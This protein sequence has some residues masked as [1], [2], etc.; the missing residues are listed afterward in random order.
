M[1]IL[2]STAATNQR[3][4]HVLSDLVKAFIDTESEIQTNLQS[5]GFID[6]GHE[7]GDGQ[8]A[9]GHNSTLKVPKEDDVLSSLEEPITANGNNSSSSPCQT[10]GRQ[11]E[12]NGSFGNHVTKRSKR[13]MN[14]DDVHV[15]FADDGPDL[16]TPAFNFSIGSD[17]SP[18]D[19]SNLSIDDDVV[20]GAS[21]RLRNAVD[22][23]LNLLK[24][25]ANLQIVN[26]GSNGQSSTESSVELVKNP[27]MITDGKTMSKNSAESEKIIEKL[28]K[29]LKDV[30]RANQVLQEE[31]NNKHRQLSSLKARIDSTNV[32]DAQSLKE[33]NDNLKLI[34]E[35][36]TKCNQDLRE[37]LMTAE[38]KVEKFAFAVNTLRKEL[39][40]KND[41]LER[42]KGHY[43][44]EGH[45]SSQFSLRSIEAVRDGS[46][47]DHGHVSPLP[48]NTLKPFEVDQLFNSDEEM[49]EEEDKD[50]H[51]DHH[52]NSHSISSSVFNNPNDLTKLYK[53][54]VAEKNQEIE[55]LKHQ[56]K[57]A[58]NMISSL[59]PGQNADHEDMIL[60]ID[61][62]EELVQELEHF[63]RQDGHIGG[64]N[65]GQISSG[66][67]FID[68][69]QQTTPI[70]MKNAGISPSSSVTSY[71]DCVQTKSVGINTDPSPQVGKVTAEQRFTLPKEIED[72]LDDAD[73]CSWSE[74][75]L[76]TNESYVDVQNLDTKL[77][78]LHTC[79][80]KLIRSNN[81]L[82]MEIQNLTR[83]KEIIFQE[84]ETLIRERRTLRD[85]KETLRKRS[86]RGSVQK[87]DS[88]ESDRK[89][90]KYKFESER[91]NRTNER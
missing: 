68:F 86:R 21:R 78:Q 39:E 61:V 30:R 23:I 9:D 35:Q 47:F 48:D 49:S 1:S 12:V 43:G 54:I 75:Q 50:K 6:G 36:L 76:S 80:E 64:Q 38:T 45:F 40:E 2:R 57:L 59:F 10:N 22:R 41:E 88:G 3:L 85:E 13:R 44:A 51:S 42:I 70:Q 31:V 73:V 19:I 89:C 17:L 81:Q 14:N 90:T 16:I 72:I 53:K 91:K 26:G 11:I 5:L 62:M 4:L 63:R 7:N 25:V 84:K 32:L 66:R 27:K 74:S 20:L 46:A 77:G 79:V 18:S 87:S 28:E 71:R 58:S 82:K 67:N 37:Q 52:D 24:T 83:E 65:S 60:D 8:D 55:I 29:E 69:N 15:E 34:N 33:T 56:M